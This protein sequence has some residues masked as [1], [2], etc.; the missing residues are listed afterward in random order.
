[1]PK[2][3]TATML[4]R[5]FRAADANGSS[6]E[7]IAVDIE[8]L[9]DGASPV[10]GGH[11]TILAAT[12]MAIIRRYM[13]RSGDAPAALL[14]PSLTAYGVM[15]P[16]AQARRQQRLAGITM[17]NFDVIDTITVPADKPI[18]EWSHRVYRSFSID[19]GHG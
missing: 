5:R 12:A 14:G 6:V 2:R 13:G 8:M 19:D 16:D 3:G 4:T 7:F 18:T 10:M 17:K 1:M 11:D 9:Y 15:W